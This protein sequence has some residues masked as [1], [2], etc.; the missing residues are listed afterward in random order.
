M[1]DPVV[2]SQEVTTVLGPDAV[3]KGAVRFDKT[4]TVRGRVE[5][6]ISTQGRL[7][8]APEGKVDASI[9]AAQLVIEGSVRGDL[10]VAQKLEL[11]PTARYEGSIT[12]GKLSVESGAAIEAF[13]AIG[14]GSAQVNAPTSRQGVRP[15]LVGAGA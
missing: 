1:P 5:G 13:L 14:T 3:F 8:V 4:L 10:V 12:A 7:H 11:K 9:D 6:S 15:A 2:T